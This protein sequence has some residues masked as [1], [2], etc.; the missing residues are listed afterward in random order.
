M[1]QSIKISVHAKERIEQLSSR[2][3]LEKHIKVSQ[4]ELLEYLVDYAL[5]DD[6]IIEKIVKDKK[7][8]K[9]S[10]KVT[11]WEEV[12][13]NPPDWNIDNLSENIDENISQE[14]D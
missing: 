5:T 14:L 8:R 2:L 3:L 11:N 13:E 12:F 1:N 7:L 9:K 6:D 10:L 4:I